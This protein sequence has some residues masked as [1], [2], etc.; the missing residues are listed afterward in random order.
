MLGVSV[1]F[2]DMDLN[3]LKEASKYNVKYV[4][5]SLHIP[6]D[7][8]DDIERK[9]PSLIDM[10]ND[11]NIY[12]VS[13]ISPFT[14][15]NLKIANK[16]FKSLKG[17][18]IKAIRLDYGI[19]DP[20]VVVKLQKDFKI[21][22]NA[23]VVDADYLLKCKDKG[24]NL[25]DIVLMHNFYPH[26]DTGLEEVYFHD[27][28]K[29]FLSLNLKIQAFVCGD[30][31]MRYPLYEGLPTLESHRGINPFVAAIE[32]NKKFLISEIFIGDSRAKIET[33][34]FIN[35]FLENNIINIKVNFE[36]EYFELYDRVFDLRGDYGSLIRLKKDRVCNVEIKHNTIRYKGSITMDNLLYGRYSGEISICK[37]ELASDSRVNVIGYIHPEYLDLLVYLN[38][39]VKIRFIKSC[40]IS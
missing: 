1:Y 30:D 8:P 25:D 5:T 36:S 14:F 12:L 39:E 13:D 18:G 9:L 17:K 19:D 35:D 38:S 11:L 29:E 33:I 31:L 40:N 21:F 15:K 37:K 20:E 22:L 10:C 28:N 3:Y 6:E 26:R 4:F 7:N 32:L 27:K 34:K 2:K 16:D 24:L 23:S